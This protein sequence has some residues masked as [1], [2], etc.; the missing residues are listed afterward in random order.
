MTTADRNRCVTCK[1][2]GPAPSTH[3]DGLC[4]RNSPQVRVH[5]PL[6]YRYWPPVTDRD[7]CGQWAKDTRADQ[8]ELQF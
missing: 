4:R 1:H 8:R 7:W 2:F 5:G 3:G 6:I